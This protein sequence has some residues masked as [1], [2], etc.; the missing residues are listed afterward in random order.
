MNYRSRFRNVA[1]LACLAL[2]VAAAPAAA[3]AVKVGEP[4]P[5]FTAT[6]S[7]GKQVS[8]AQFKGKYVVLEWHNQGCPYVVKHYRSGN[9]PKLQKEWT[10]KQ[11]VWLAIISSAPGKQGFVDGKGAN[12]DMQQHS[13]APTATLL[14]PKGE[15][16]QLYGAKTT[17]HMFIINPQG[18]LIYNGAIDDKSSSD[19][20]DIPGAKNYVA[21]ALTEALAGK[22]V[23]QSTTT[24]YGCSVKY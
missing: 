16:G 18:Q 15:V 4:A 8:L 23:S 3:L 14:D 22:P 20:A 12:Q 1:A 24:P 9:L 6:D 5:A 7:N 19:P 11:V 10:A 21:Q 2:A 13:A 17:P